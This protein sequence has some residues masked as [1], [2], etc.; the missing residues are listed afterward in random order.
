MTMHKIL[1]FKRF[2]RI[3][4]WSQMALIF[5]LL[6]SGFAV[7]GVH[8]LIN[9]GDAVTVHTWTAIVLLLIWAFAIFWLFTTGQWRHYIPTGEN[10]VKVARFYAFGIFKGEH[11]PY[12]KTYRRKHNPLQ[13]LTYLLLK[14]VIF[15]AIWISGIAYLLISFGQE[16]IFGWIGLGL[17]ALIHT[18][19]A[20]AVL[21]FVIAHV[22]LLTTGHSFI[23]HVKPMITGYDD[24]ELS[25]EELAYL[26][27]DE[28]GAIKEA[29]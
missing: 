23:D 9:F 18:I 10:F 6:F 24:V 22:Y 20:I 11:H 4:H 15:P 25:D 7:H 19:A 26:K 17:I 21:V 29:D 8:S 14:I 2:E 12:R 3:W 5:T 1:V 13:A 16:D 28:P 27:A